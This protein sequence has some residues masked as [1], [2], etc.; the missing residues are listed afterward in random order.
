MLKKP[1]KLTPCGRSIT[2]LMHNSVQEKAHAVHAATLKVRGYGSSLV[3]EL[4]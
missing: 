2:K 3:Y 1:V 4:E